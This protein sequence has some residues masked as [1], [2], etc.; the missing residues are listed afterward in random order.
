MPG[1]GS[2]KSKTQQEPKGCKDWQDQ[3]DIISVGAR[4]MPKLYYTGVPHSCSLH[5]TLLPV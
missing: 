3:E 2:R 5:V 4:P 1:L